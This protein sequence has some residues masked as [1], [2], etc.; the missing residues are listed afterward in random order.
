[1]T[2]KLEVGVEEK[3]YKIMTLPNNLGKWNE[4]TNHFF[5]F[6]DFA[7]FVDCEVER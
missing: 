3:Q 5:F 2:S 6:T 1:L 7:M 4:D